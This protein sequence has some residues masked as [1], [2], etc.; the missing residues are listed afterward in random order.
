MDVNDKLTGVARKGAERGLNQFRNLS[1]ADQ[2]AL[3]TLVSEDPDRRETA[4]RLWL[5]S[6]SATS[7]YDLLNSIGDAAAAN[8]VEAQRDL[9]HHG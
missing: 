5:R 8:A 3:V 2:H 7:I 6:L 9:A 4:I 1:K